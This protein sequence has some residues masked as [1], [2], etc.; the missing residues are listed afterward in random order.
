MGTITLAALKKAVDEAAK[1]WDS[2]EV[3]VELDSFA[4]FEESGDEV[5]HLAVSA[6][7]PHPLVLT[8]AKTPK[9]TFERK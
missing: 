4:D 7:W 9:P 1:K 3:E 5:L 2:D 8:D 6:E